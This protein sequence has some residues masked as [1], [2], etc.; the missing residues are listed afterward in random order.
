MKSVL[1]ILGIL[2]IGLNSCN[3]ETVGYLMTK[4]ASY[5]PDSLVIRKT[6]DPSLD[7]TRI[8]NDAPWVSYKLQGF[9][10]TN[11]IDFSIESVVSSQG[12]E[13]AREFMNE[14]GIRGGDGVMT[15]PLKNKVTPGRYTVSIRLTNPG[16]SQ[17]VKDAFTFVVVE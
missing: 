12:E 2:I 9:V 14:L 5:K 7:A 4:D 17:V 6:P 15:F 11:P 13:M 1:I 8:K 16:Y 10:G 3:Q